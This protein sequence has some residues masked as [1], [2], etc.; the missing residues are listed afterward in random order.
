MQFLT[1][2]EI[3]IKNQNKGK[4]R[5]NKRSPFGRSLCCAGL[6]QSVVPP[7]V[8]Q[9]TRKEKYKS[10][11]KRTLVF[12]F[13]SFPVS[14]R[15][16]PAFVVAAASA[17]PLPSFT[18]RKA[19]FASA[20]TYFFSGCSLNQPSRSAPLKLCPESRNAN[21]DVNFFRAVPRSQS[22]RSSASSTAP[23]PVVA[24]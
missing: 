22:L 9:T 1:L 12:F 15:S 6:F 11:E 19:V 23:S 4:T 3:Q 16:L 10:S 17:K 18:R 5:A 20:A 7:S 21:A 8:P 13:A 14:T 24:V 2:G